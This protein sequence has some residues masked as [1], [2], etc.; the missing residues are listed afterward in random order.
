M[1][2]YARKVDGNHR[3]VIDHL[4]DIGWRVHDTSRLGGGFPDATAYHDR[5]GL[6]LLEIKMPGEKLTAK[7]REFFALFDGAP[8]HQI[9]SAEAFL[10]TVGA[11]E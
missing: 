8:V 9:E 11:I 4:R 7:E 2:R 3:Q 1:S 10:K 6:H 5:F